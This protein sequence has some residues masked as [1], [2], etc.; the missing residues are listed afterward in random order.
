MN[1]LCSATMLSNL[2]IQHYAYLSL[3]PLKLAT[4][5]TGKNYSIR[6][7]METGS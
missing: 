7:D 5:D 6:S 2:P 3:E 1:L 4:M